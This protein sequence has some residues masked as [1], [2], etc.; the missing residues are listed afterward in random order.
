MEGSW[1]SCGRRSVAGSEECCFLII[2][3]SATAAS[4]G[5]WLESGTECL[6][7][8]LDRP[9]LTDT[10]ERR[11]AA[12]AV[13]RRAARV[14]LRDGKN[15]ECWTFD[16]SASGVGVM[17]DVALPKGELCALGFSILFANDGT[18]AVKV[19]A[20]IA[21]SV[22]SS[23]RGGFKIGLAFHQPSPALLQAIDRYVGETTQV[24][25]ES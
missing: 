20:R 5:P 8:Q 1:P 16:I 4:I 22:F 14:V 21:Y 10:P 9:V 15:V 12:R 2:A 17:S 19:A 23:D 7:P 25:R 13:M 24:F 18:Y 11:V 3:K 6:G